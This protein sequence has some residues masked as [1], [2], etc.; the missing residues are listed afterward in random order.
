MA[1][2]DF[3]SEEVSDQFLVLTKMIYYRSERL[4]V[5]SSIRVKEV[6]QERS[7]VQNTRAG[8]WYW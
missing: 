2:I 3:S 6:G 4:T 7:S 5:I 1:L 8:S